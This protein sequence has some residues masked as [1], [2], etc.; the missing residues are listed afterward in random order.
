MDP[1]PI[2]AHEKVLKLSSGDVEFNCCWNRTFRH[3]SVQSNQER[4][5]RIKFVIAALV[6]LAKA[7][8]RT[9]VL[10]RYIRDK[11]EWAVPTHAVVNIATLGVPYYRVMTQEE[12]YRYIHEGVRENS[13]VMYAGRNYSDTHHRINGSNV[14][15]LGINKICSMRDHELPSIIEQR[16]TSMKWCL[17]K[18]LKWS[19][20][21]GSWIQFCQ[22]E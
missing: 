2:G 8:N 5:L 14:K 16:I 6:E 19:E 17:D 18:D 7:T 20:A 11:F 21:I 13:Q 15:V 3:K 22:E 9:L 10:P 12:S 4:Q 1:K